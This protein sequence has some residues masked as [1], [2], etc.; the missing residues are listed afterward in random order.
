[1]YTWN[2]VRV[3][4]KEARRRKNVGKEQKG[5]TENRKRLKKLVG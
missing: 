3:G 4:F 2:K 1:M 5:N